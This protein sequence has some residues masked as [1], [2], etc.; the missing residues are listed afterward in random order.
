VGTAG[1]S[2]LLPWL[3]LLR[4]RAPRIDPL[5]VHSL[6]YSQKLDGATE[7]VLTQKRPKLRRERA[8]ERAT[9]TERAGGAARESACGGVR[10]AQPLG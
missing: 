9:R 8:R 6:S 4:P 7:K 10:G 5:T 2:D 3:T 1:G